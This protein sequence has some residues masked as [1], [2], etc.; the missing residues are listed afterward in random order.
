MKGA[1]DERQR[2]PGRRSPDEQSDIRGLWPRISASDIRDHCARLFTA[3]CDRGST[4]SIFRK[5]GHRFSLENAT[6]KEAELA[7][8][9]R[10]PAPAITRTLAVN[11][12]RRTVG[13][14]LVDAQLA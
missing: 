9:A 12:Q 14:N 13:C 11:S 1:R 10:P 7:S 5:S 3:P 6:T 8:A 4:L 2:H